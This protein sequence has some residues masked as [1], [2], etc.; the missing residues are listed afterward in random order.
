MGVPIIFNQP[1]SD[2]TPL[3]N[4]MKLIKSRDEIEKMLV[5]GEFADKTMQSWLLIISHS[6]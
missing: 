1:F 3:I 5:A 6:T 4:T 2:I